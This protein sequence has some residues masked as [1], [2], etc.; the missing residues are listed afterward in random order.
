MNSIII[1]T[2]PLAYIYPATPFLNHVHTKKLVSG[3]SFYAHPILDVVIDD[4]VYSIPLYSLKST[5]IKRTN[6]VK[7]ICPY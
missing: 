5:K 4:E 7:W 2:N 6:P 3:S 1:D